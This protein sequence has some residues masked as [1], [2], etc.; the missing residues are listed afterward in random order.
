MMILVL[1]LGLTAVF[2]HILFL[3]IQSLLIFFILAFSCTSIRTSVILCHIKK[4][5]NLGAALPLTVE[6][7][8]FSGTLFLPQEPGSKFSSR[9]LLWSGHSIVQQ[10]WNF[11]GQQ[12]WRIVWMLSVFISPSAFTSAAGSSLLFCVMEVQWSG[13]LAFSEKCSDNQ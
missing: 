1:G 9:V 12:R 2:L 13:L 7:G 5:V 3:I 11:F 4:P 8:P 10:T 6:S